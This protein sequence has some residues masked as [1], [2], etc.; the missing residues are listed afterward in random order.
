MC[1]RYAH[2]SRTAP[3]WTS[4]ACGPG[5][6]LC[7]VGNT[8][9]LVYPRRSRPLQC[10]AGTAVSGDLEKDMAF[11]GFLTFLDRPKEGVTEVAGL[12]G[13]G[14]TLKVIR[15]RQQAGDRSC[16]AAWSGC[17]RKHPHGRGA[18]ERLDGPGF[19]APVRASTLRQ[20][21]PDQKEHHP[22]PAR[23]WHA[24]WATWAIA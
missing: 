20:V 14:V 2:G 15:R 3:H 13:I 10:Q 7:R 1:W 19:Q 18:A 8:G 11:A 5:R 23:R 9:V 24:W 17:L 21:D 22:R 12:A 16:G 6:T 4:G